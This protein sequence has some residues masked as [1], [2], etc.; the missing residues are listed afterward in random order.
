MNNGIDGLSLDLI[1]R[2]TQ[3]RLPSLVDVDHTSV[4]RH[5]MNKV[6][7]IVEQVLIGLQLFKNV[8]F[9]LSD[10]MMAEANLRN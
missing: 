6:V 8:C 10:T 4:G 5:Q 9:Q 2:I 1:L 7:G 3:D